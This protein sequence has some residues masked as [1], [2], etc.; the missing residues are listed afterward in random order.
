M[1][2]NINVKKKGKQS[3]QFP[4]VELSKGESLRQLFNK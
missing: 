4:M 2:K 3:K 1:P